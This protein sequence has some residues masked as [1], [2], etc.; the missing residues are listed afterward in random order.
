MRNT[1]LWSAALAL[2]LGM[3]TPGPIVA[4]DTSSGDL[5]TVLTVSVA[6][7][8]AVMESVDA[9][10]KAA[11]VPEMTML[12]KM[13]LGGPKGPGGLDGSKPL[14][15]VLQTDGQQFP[16]M[17]FAPI[18]DAEQFLAFLKGFVKDIPEPDADGVYAIETGNQ[19]VYIQQ[20]NG[21]AFAV[22]E[23]DALADTP[24]D[25][26]ALLGGM[27]KDFAVGIRAQ[28]GNIPQP[29]RDSAMMFMQMAASAGSQRNDGETDEQYALRQKMTK[30]SMDEIQ[31]LVKEMDSLTI[32]LGVNA[33]DGAINLDVAVTAAEGTSLAK[34]MAE[35]AGLKSA[36]TGFFNPD[37]ALTVR[38]T[39]KLSES[40]V[41]QTLQVL[42]VAKTQATEAIESEDLGEAKTK[43]ALELGE[44]LLAVV[45]GMIKGRTVDGGL[46]L[47]AGDKGITLITGG[48][49]AG[50]A[51]LDD[52]FK[53]VVEQAREE[54]PDLD[55]FLKMNVA[56]HKDV[57]FHT[58]AVPAAL[59]FKDGVPPAYT[60]SDV[61]ITIGFGDSAVYLAHGADPVALLKAAI[62][63]SAAASDAAAVP[64]Q[65]SFSASAIG[66]L[67]E[68]I[69]TSEEAD[70]PP[71]LIAAL[72]QAGDRDHVLISTD[73]IPNGMKI[74]FTI[75]GGVLKVIGA[76]AKAAGAAGQPGF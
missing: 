27:E 7:Y 51:K 70:I 43:Q 29:L 8:D 58:L 26:A 72:K 23:K 64:A 38:V 5:K 60:D 68:L 2:V 13:M 41:T 46:S 31:K 69:G 17:L 35:A 65:F 56:Q 54:E 12:P 39:G 30:Q 20:K 21:W 16:A 10:A 47:E 37:A 34:D 24:A 66:N 62:D 15:L 74:R 55:Q 36:F 22:I 1:V 3:A 50:A 53:K 33:T 42:D 61:K 44:E 57:K 52:I 14:G 49:V 73:A 25:P 6:G 67:L 45:K 9:L 32:G 28:V 19:T 48:H 63:R 59:V 11:G 18:T 40:D 71:E 76:A 4:Q 75:E